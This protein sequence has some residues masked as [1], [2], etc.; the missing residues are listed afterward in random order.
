MD[1]PIENKVA[2]SGLITLNLEEYF[3]PGERVVL[4]IVPWLFEGVILREKPF[5]EFIDTHD[6][7]SYQDKFVAVLCSEDAII[8]TWAYMLIASRLQSFAKHFVIGTLIDLE[9]DL[10]QMAVRQIKPEDYL[11][12]RVVIKGCS[13]VDVPASVYAEITR[14]LKPVVKSIFYGEPCSTVPVYKAPK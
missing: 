12:S 4:D 3:V 14:I 1:Q 11:G 5:R 2:S 7:A 10:F 6:W 13:K 8:P 9:K